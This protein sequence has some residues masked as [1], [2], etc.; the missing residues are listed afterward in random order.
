MHALWQLALFGVLV[1]FWIAID[2]MKKRMRDRVQG[3][4]R[5]RLD[6]REFQ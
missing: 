5:E 1:L 6:G 4:H 2:Q 3:S